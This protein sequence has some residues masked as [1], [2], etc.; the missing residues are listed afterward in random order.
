M[1]L[2]RNRSILNYVI[3]VI[4]KGD[5]VI[6]FASLLIAIMLSEQASTESIFQMDILFKQLTTIPYPY[7]YT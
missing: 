4:E 7:V 2:P 3:I 6:M 1:Q 5:P